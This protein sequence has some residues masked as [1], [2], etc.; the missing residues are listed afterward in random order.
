MLIP[1]FNFGE[2]ENQELGTK[3]STQRQNYR[4]IL[5][6]RIKCLGSWLLILGSI[7]P[8][9]NPLTVKNIIPKD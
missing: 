5:I 7:F 9:F 4:V 3:I 1:F 8:T 2:F 6:L